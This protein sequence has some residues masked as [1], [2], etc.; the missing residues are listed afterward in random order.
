MAQDPSVLSQSCVRCGV[1]NLRGSQFCNNCR[2]YLRDTTLTVERVTYN[3]RFWGSNLLEGLL[4]I[5]TLFI[6]WLIWFW[7]TSKTGQSPAKRLLDIYVIRIEEGRNIG[8]GDAWVREV[9]VKMVLINWIAGAL[10]GGLVGLIDAIWVL[11]D[12]DRQALHDK[13]LSQIV[14]YAPAGLP[15]AM[16]HTSPHQP[17][18]EMRTLAADLAELARLRDAGMITAQEYEQ[19]RARIV[20]GVAAQSGE[21]DDTPG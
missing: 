13:M 7:F 5:A 8:R 15:E 17:S 12:K 10:S 11:F 9:A 3:R 6:G 1:P 2:L 16:R 19:R 20:G 21:M 14:V 18:A 4:M